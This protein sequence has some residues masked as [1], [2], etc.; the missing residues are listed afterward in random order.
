MLIGLKFTYFGYFSNTYSYAS[1]QAGPSLV[2]GVKQ[3]D[4]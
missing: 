3:V 4:V 2:C 1:S